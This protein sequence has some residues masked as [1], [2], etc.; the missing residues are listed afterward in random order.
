MSVWRAARGVTAGQ[1]PRRGGTVPGRSCSSTPIDAVHVVGH[2]PPRGNA[3]LVSEHGGAYFV[4]TDGRAS[5]AEPTAPVATRG[6]EQPPKG[7]IL[8]IDT[9]TVRY[10]SFGAFSKIAAVV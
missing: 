4:Q 9:S 2:S 6:R 7:R 3:C 5:G 10:F 8:E 1:T